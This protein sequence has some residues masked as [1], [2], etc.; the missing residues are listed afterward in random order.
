MQKQHELIK[1]QNTKKYLRTNYSKTKKYTHQTIFPP[2][3]NPISTST[4][5]SIPTQSLNTNTHPHSPLIT[6]PPSLKPQP[7]APIQNSKTQK[8]LQKNKKMQKQTR[9][10]NI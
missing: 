5:K 1:N 3:H 4:L 9:S 2:F 7:A 8:N 10:K 6:P